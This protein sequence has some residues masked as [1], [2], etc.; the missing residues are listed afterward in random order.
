M[1]PINM[2]PFVTHF[3]LL[4]NIGLGLLNAFEIENLP[5]ILLILLTLLVFFYDN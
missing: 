2:K 5:F 1:S 4:M 3:V